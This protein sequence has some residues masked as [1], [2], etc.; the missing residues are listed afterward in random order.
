[1]SGRAGEVSECV[2]VREREK[3]VCVRRGVETLPDFQRISSKSFQRSQD[4]VYVQ[5]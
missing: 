2:C 5:K 1:M 3:R 4:E